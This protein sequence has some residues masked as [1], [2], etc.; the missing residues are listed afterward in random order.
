M[1][2]FTITLSDGA[3]ARLQA[4]AAIEGI[5]PRQFLLGLIRHMLRRAESEARSKAEQ[6]SVDTDIAVT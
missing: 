3:V 4:L 5:P 6:A 1:P 2:D